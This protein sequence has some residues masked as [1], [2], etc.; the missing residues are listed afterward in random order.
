MTLYVY[1]IDYI[2]AHKL[3]EASDY[4][5]WLKETTPVL[6]EHHP[7][8]RRERPRTLPVMSLKSTPT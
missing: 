1:E 4:Q 6:Y 3:N 2:A 8:R 5:V 7:L